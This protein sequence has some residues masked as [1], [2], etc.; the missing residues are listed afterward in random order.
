VS[1]GGATDKIYFK[2]NGTWIAATKVY[3]KIN[4]SWVQ[5]SDLTQVFDN[6]KNYVKGN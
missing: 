1:P 2:N 5:Q 6:S 4:G 3:K